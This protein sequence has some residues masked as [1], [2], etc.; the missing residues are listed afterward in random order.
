MK[1]KF[2]IDENA[3]DGSGANTTTHKSTA[4]DAGADDDQTLLTLATA[5]NGTPDTATDDASAASDVGSLLAR[6]GATAGGLGADGAATKGYV[7]EWVG[8]GWG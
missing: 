2:G 6:G 3:T 5:A 1:H 8:A 7:G 4:P